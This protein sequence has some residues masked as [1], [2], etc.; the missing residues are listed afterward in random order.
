[1][2]VMNPNCFCSNGSLYKTITIDYDYNKKIDFIRLVNNLLDIKRLMEFQ[3]F[4]LHVFVYRFNAS[5]GK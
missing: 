1:M 5:I 4:S 2:Q 3:I